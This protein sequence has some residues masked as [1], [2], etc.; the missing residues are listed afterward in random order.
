LLDSLGIA[1]SAP[2]CDRR[3]PVVSDDDGPLPTSGIDQTHDVARELVERIS[4]DAARLLARIVP[5]L[6]G[7]DDSISRRSQRSDLL[8]PAVPELGESVQ[9]DHERSVVRPRDDRM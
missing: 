8:A 9:Q 4:A 1:D 3:A 7:S 2:P 5:A 6:I